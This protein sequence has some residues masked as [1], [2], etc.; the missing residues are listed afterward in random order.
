MAKT[1]AIIQLI[2]TADQD[3][4]ARATYFQAQVTA[5]DAA[6]GRVYIQRIDDEDSL[7]DVEPYTSI[8]ESQPAIGEWVLMANWGRSAVVLGAMHRTSPPLRI[9]PDIMAPPGLALD[10]ANNS[11]FTSNSTFAIY[12]GRADRIITT[13]TVRVQVTVAAVTI[14]WAEVAIGASSAFAVGDS[15]SIEEKGFTNVAASFNTTGEKSVTVTTS[16]IDRGDN[17][18]L[19][20]GS[21]ATTPFQLYGAI[22]GRLSAGNL[23]AKSSTR[24]STMVGTPSFSALVDS[25]GFYGLVTLE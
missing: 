4:L 17:V 9:I 3:T 23:Q 25:A 18:W 5:I 10:D 15:V 6:T 11:A 20:V 8:M 2:Q 7:P 12:L 1:D 21:Q 19:L 22:G 16:A 24:P 14:T 13:A